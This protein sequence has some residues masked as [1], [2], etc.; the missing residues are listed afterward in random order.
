[1]KTYNNYIAVISKCLFGSLEF[2][3]NSVRKPN[4]NQLQVFLYDGIKSK[5]ATPF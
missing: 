4:K 2:V 1:M 3:C 5:R